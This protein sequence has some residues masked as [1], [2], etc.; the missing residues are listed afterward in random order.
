MSNSKLATSHYW[1][2]NFSSRNGT[3][4]TKIIIHH[5]ATVN[6]TAKSCY[7][8]W[9]K[10]QGSAHYAIDRYGNIGQLIDEKYRA[11]SV[12]N[13]AADSQ[14]VTIEI[15]NTTASPY[16]KVSDA[17]VKACIKLCADICRRNGIKRLNFTGNKSGNL[18]MHCYYMATA[19]PG[20]TLKK[21]FS[22][23]AA[24][25]NK[26]LGAKPA[27]KEKT[28]PDYDTP[29]TVKVECN[30]LYIR[31]GPG[32]AKYG[33]QKVDGSE[34]IKPGVYTIMAVQVGDGYYWGKLKS[35]T[36]SSPRWIALDYTKFMK[37][38]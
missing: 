31:K 13:E 29:F 27:P 4:I 19:C 9:K 18:V 34:F 32:I 3:K 25:V 23:I 11:W 1:T 8:T 7:Y 37:E 36:A 24:E 16:W 35:S 5:M 22:Y 10:R 6:G 30:D 14:A 28:W 26:L 15:A 33:R 21:K 17:S 2:K 38:V 12:A 20:P